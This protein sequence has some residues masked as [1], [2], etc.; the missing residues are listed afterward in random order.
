MRI[1]GLMLASLVTVREEKLMVCER[2]LQLMV[3]V[4]NL[5]KSAEQFWCSPRVC[6]IMIEI[7]LQSVLS[8]GCSLEHMEGFVDFLNLIRICEIALQGHQYCC[9]FANFPFSS[10]KGKYQDQV[11]PF[12]FLCLLSC[13]CSSYEMMTNQLVLEHTLVTSCVLTHITLLSG[14]DVMQEGLQ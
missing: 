10:D 9:F 1:Q 3:C 7:S 11:T 2:R 5:R 12:P 13:W 6:Q 8:N 4:R 14:R